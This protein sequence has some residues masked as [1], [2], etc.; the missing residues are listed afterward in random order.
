MDRD[1]SRS[2]A[3]LI[4][5][6]AYGHPDVPDL[7]GVPKSLAAMDKLLTGDLCG[8]PADRVT[9]LAEVGTPSE[10]A[11]A[12][13][14]A[15]RDVEDVLLVYFVGHGAPT[16]DGR[17]AL[18]LAR[19]DPHPEALP[20]T[21]MLYEN[22]ASIMRGCPAATK[23]VILDCCHAELSTRSHFRFQSVS[24]SEAYP[25]DGLYAIGASAA[26]RRAK[27]PLDG[28]MTF[29]TD[30]FVS[31]VEAGIPGLGPTLRLD[32]IFL[33]LRLRLLR[34]NRPE[35]VESGIRGA[36]RFPFARN[37]AA[38]AHPPARDTVPADPPARDPL[39]HDAMRAPAPH[40]SRRTVLM[41][42]AS[43]LLF[44]L[45]GIWLS[46]DRPRATALSPSD[47]H[48]PQPG[49]TRGGAPTAS[50]TTPAASAVHDARP[51]VVRGAA[52]LAAPL[53]G[54]SFVTSVAF[55][56]DG[57][58]LA[59][60]GND[61]MIHL[62]DVTDPARGVATVASLSGHE[63]SVESIAYSPDGTMLASAGD[64]ATV[65]LWGTADP[66]RAAVVGRPLTG[67]RGAVWS[68]AYSP[69]GGMLAS[70]GD[71]G[72]VRLWDVADP[73]RA[74]QLGAPLTTSRGSTGAVALGPDGRVLAA[75]CDNGDVLLWD[76]SA[77][78]RPVQLPKALL[79][80]HR[81]VP[82]LAFAPDGRTLAAGSDDGT[83][84]LWNITD[85]SRPVR[86]GKPLTGHHDT[87]WSLAYSPDGRTL[88]SGG[89]DRRIFLWNTA[90]PARIVRIGQ[91]LDG[92]HNDV[93]SVAI[94][95]SGRLMAGACGDGTVQLWR[96]NG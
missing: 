20:H 39:A 74:R 95:R 12:A 38:S 54:D 78:A 88:A 31:V 47:S 68:V 57:R 51:F 15:V 34:A 82:S 35:P 17:L 1:L 25:V 44:S 64:D 29:F 70:G 49:P 46:G 77:P 8:W 10:L 18:M 93:S 6:A 59:S 27:S 63:G 72:T 60:G 11:V 16:S 21:A 37:A 81:Y 7:P 55:D 45:G 71:D 9:C 89:N 96:L 13:V 79:G 33:D 58:T 65:R 22:L 87:V 76:V 84:L 86:V 5:N 2:R 41:A 62:W 85:P 36:H 26:N 80:H 56:T 94:A 42:S 52:P 43:A 30:A 73:A 4:G 3:L 50:S 40:N 66:T 14:A 90:D 19:T 67:H 32:Q 48:R 91:P 24:L 92:Y 75:G 23:L 53:S 28:S 61:A 83:I 69:A